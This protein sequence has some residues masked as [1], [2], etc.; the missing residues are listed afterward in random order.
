M[1]DPAFLFY[2]NDFLSGT[3]TMS[4]EQVGK[5]I[6][7][8][9][10]QHQKGKLSEKDMINICISHD[11]DIWSKFQKDDDG[12]YQNTRLFDEMERRNRYSESRRNNRLNAKKEDSTK[13]NKD[14]KVSKSYVKHMETETITINEDSINRESTLIVVSDTARELEK[15][16]LTYPFPSDYFRECWQQWKEY[17]AN[18]HKDKYKSVDTEQRALITIGNHF[19]TEKE[20]IDAMHLAITNRW[21]GFMFPDNK[22]SNTK[23]NGKQKYSAERVAAAVAK[24]VGRDN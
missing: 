15:K 9:C 24:A 7:L 16:I 1:K 12:F 19:A 5:Y 20:A 22:S 21:H 8:L 23:P 18:E 13:K 11:E 14:K 6:R 4:N 17:K 10:L 3:F 2:S